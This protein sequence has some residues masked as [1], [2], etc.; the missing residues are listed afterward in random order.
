MEFL[1]GILPLEPE[2]RRPSTDFHKRQ[3]TYLSNT[4]K[5]IQT[6]KTNRILPSLLAAGALAL[7]PGVSESHAQAPAP[8]TGELQPPPPPLPPGGPQG[9]R[10]PAPSRDERRPRSGDPGPPP[11]P[12]ELAR[13]V[14]ARNASTAVKTVTDAVPSFASGQV[15]VKTAPLGEQQ[16]EASL[17]FQGKEVARLALNPADGAILPK[18]MR[19]APPSPPPGGAPPPPQPGALNANAP[20]PPPAPGAIVTPE[21]VKARLTDMVKALRPAGGAEVMPREG[22]WRVPFV[23]QG[24]IVA[25]VQVTA[26]GARILPDLSAARDAAIFAR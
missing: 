16:M 13:P 26:D 24:A 9:E 1:I 19:T 6:M 22:F 14:D 4:K 11:P 15:W 23:Y 21:Q 25:D 17:L 7:G 8:P 5:R 2:A 18:G 3:T 12:E 10:A 20:V